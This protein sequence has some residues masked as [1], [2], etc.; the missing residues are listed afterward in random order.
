MS[1]TGLEVSF[2]MLAHCIAWMVK[3]EKIAKDTAAGI[4]GFAFEGMFV[5]A[6][7]AV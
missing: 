2:L 4:W 3:T 1:G 6:L 5:G 7:I